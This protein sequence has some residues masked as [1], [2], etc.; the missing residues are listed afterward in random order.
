MVGVSRVGNDHWY[1]G[2]E[3]VAAGE[4]RVG[5]VEKRLDLECRGMSPGL[6]HSWHRPVANGWQAKKRGL[7]QGC[8]VRHRWREPVHVVLVCGLW[9]TVFPW[10]V[11]GLFYVHFI[12]RGVVEVVAAGGGRERGRGGGVFAVGGRGR[13]RD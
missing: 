3:P 5:V 7:L 11:I 2:A 6:R 4:V 8:C 9:R 13:G 12:A 10:F 1:D